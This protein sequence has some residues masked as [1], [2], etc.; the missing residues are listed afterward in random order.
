MNG[1]PASVKNVEEND[2]RFQFDQNHDVFD[3]SHPDVYSVTDG[4]SYVN[5]VQNTTI[6]ESLATTGRVL[7][8]HEPQK[9]SKYRLKYSDSLTLVGKEGDQS[10]YQRDELQCGDSRQL[11]NTDRPNLLKRLESIRAWGRN[12]LKCTKQVIEEKL[13]TSSPTCDENLDLRIESLR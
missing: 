4:H 3:S 2:H 6:S 8:S 12:T 10:V 5:G 9:E 7:H 11:A 1:Y 13:G